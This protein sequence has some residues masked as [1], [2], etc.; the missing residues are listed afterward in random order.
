MGER[1]RKMCPV[2][3]RKIKMDL[4]SEVGEIRRGKEEGGRGK[5]R[6]EKIKRD[7]K[8]GRVR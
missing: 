2:K 6:K 8:G 4:K 3:K 5:A 1:R 7:K